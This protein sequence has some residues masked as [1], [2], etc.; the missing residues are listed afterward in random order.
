MQAGNLGCMGMNLTYFPMWGLTR[1]ITAST[2]IHVSDT[3]WSKR[4]VQH[5]FSYC[6]VR[7]S[8]HVS[9][10][11]WVLS[12][13]DVWMCMAGECISMLL[14][15]TQRGLLTSCGSLYVCCY[16][17]MQNIM[18]R[19]CVSKVNLLRMLLVMVY[20]DFSKQDFTWT[21]F[22]LYLSC[23]LAGIIV[24]ICISND[25]GSSGIEQFSFLHH[26]FISI[27]NTFG[28]KL[29]IIDILVFRTGACW[30]F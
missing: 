17:P 22:E 16:V 10:G 3:V 11:W 25:T 20:F 12:K 7:L 29:D 24:I 14:V 9:A 13:T 28:F 1:S 4:H 19:R 8:Y 21:V 27:A 5:W 26:W 18:K 23:L 15:L 2:I 30:S 6:V